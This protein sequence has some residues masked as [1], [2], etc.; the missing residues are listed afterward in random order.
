MALCPL[1][2]CPDQTLSTQAESGWP[3][4]RVIVPTGLRAAPTPALLPYQE[5]A[6]FCP[7]LFPTPTEVVAHRFSPESNTV[8]TLSDV[9]FP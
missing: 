8:I 9:L 2:D 6:G 1:P 4:Q 7:M 3:H 5:D